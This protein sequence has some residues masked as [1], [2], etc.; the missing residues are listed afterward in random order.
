[1]KTLLTAFFLTLLCAQVPC[2]AAEVH[3]PVVSDRTHSEN[4]KILG[5]APGMKTIDDISH[6]GHAGETEAHETSSPLDKMDDE[7][8][9]AAA[10]RIL[11]GK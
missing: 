6:S 1:M 10:D 11:K 9:D 5:E 2:Y 8:T 4:T 3:K 7:M